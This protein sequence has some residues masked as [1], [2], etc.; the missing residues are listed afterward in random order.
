MAY[1]LL[2]I[3]SAGTSLVGKR[4]SDDNGWGWF[5]RGHMTDWSPESYV[6]TIS[7]NPEMQEL[8]AKNPMRQ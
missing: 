8:A 4:W 7:K 6:C 2:V 1:L 3:M 5:R